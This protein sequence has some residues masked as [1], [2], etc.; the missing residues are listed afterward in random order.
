M[1]FIYKSFMAHMK[2][3]IFFNFI[4]HGEIRSNSKIHRCPKNE[5]VRHLFPL[6]K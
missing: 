3:L 6:K 4:D 1:Q 5:S 2:G